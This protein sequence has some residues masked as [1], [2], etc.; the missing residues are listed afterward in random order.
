MT[1]EN[2]KVKMKITR[3]FLETLK[4]RVM[5]ETDKMGFAGVSS[6]VP[7][8]AELDNLLIIIDGKYAEII[9]TVELQQIDFCE[10]INELAYLIQS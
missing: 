9:D 1:V 8:I 10:D 6:P 3:K 4:F 5:N 7:L 2:E